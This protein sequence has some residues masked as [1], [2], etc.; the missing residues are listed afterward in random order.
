MAYNMGARS[1]E[2][3]ELLRR[4]AA[5]QQ[6]QTQTQHGYTPNATVQNYQQQ[7]TTIQGQKPT[8]YN[9][10]YQSGIDQLFDK[11]L[12]RGKFEY[13]MNADTLYKQAMDKYSQQAKMGM[14]DTMGQAQAMTGGY[15]NSYAQTAGQQVYDKTMQNVTDMLPAM[16]ERAYSRWRGEG[17]DM[18]RNLAMS[19]GMEQD[20]YGR[21]RDARGDWQF[22][23]GQALDRYNQER[24]FDY[25]AHM[26]KINTDFNQS[27][28]DYKKEQDS[29]NFEYGKERDEKNDAFLREKFEFDKG[30]ALSDQEFQ[31]AKF[32]YQKSMDAK[33]EAWKQLQ[34]DTQQAAASA[35][36]SSGGKSAKAYNFSRDEYFEGVDAF[37]NGGYE[38]LKQ[39]LMSFAVNGAS[40]EDI[41]MYKNSVE[42]SANKAPQS[43]NVK[44]PDYNIQMTD[45]L[46]KRLGL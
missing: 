20:E 36:K 32:E 34:W 6:Q 4:Q 14:Q 11:I 3:L 8:G 17:D 45:E 28:F 25:G 23:Y 18:A 26:D 9:S 5:Q 40:D 22:D 7:A 42:Q 27:Q 21:Y 35:P 33:D 29:K 15:G 2:E 41:A 43:N 1:E 31:Q 10:K 38:A 12:N 39:V 37:E 44:T 19:Q 13:D 16:E 30:R 24:G 46:R